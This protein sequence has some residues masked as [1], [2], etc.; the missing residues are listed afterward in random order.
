MLEWLAEYFAE[1]SKGGRKTARLAWGDLYA[2]F[3]EPY[4][5]SFQRYDIDIHVFRDVGRIGGLY[6][7]LVKD[8]TYQQYFKDIFKKRLNFTKQRRYGGF[9]LEEVTVGK[10]SET[11]FVYSA[12]PINKKEKKQKGKK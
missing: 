8:L 7:L 12:P 1:G 6:R 4:P 5:T 2:V 3:Y 10:T 11:V 9:T